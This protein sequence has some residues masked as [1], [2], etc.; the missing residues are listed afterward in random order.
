MPAPFDF[1]L[2]DNLFLKK[3]PFS[4]RGALSLIAEIVAAV[5]DCR[6]SSLSSGWLQKQVP[7]Q[8]SQRNVGAPVELGYPSSN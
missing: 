7:L 2:T 3:S 5:Y 4:R 8:Q 1:A 6:S